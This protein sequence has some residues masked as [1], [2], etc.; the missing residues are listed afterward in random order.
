MTKIIKTHAVRIHE[1]A[2][3]GTY[4]GMLLQV[5]LII[6]AAAAARGVVVRVGVEVREGVVANW[7]RD[8]DASQPL[9]AGP[10]LTY[11]QT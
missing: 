4:A 1:Q 7:F 3:H 6:Q 8:E 5:V 10:G 2:A 9:P 11:S